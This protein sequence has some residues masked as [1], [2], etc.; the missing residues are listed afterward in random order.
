MRAFV[1]VVDGAAEL[2][3]Q[4]DEHQ[5]RRNDLRQRARRGDDARRELPV[6]AV[7]QHD[8]QRDEPH[9]NDARRHDARG[10]RQQRADENHG[11]G[12][13]AAQRAEQLPHGLEQVL[14]HARAFEDQPHEGEERDRQQRVV[15]HHVVDAARHGLQQCPGQRDHA[16]RMRR[17]LDADD[18]EDEPHCAERERD[19]IAEQQRHDERRE[20][21]RRQILGH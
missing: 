16:A 19:G 8:R 7:A 17:K 14:G 9:G 1:H 2:V 18:E 5:R 13:A 6:I 15:A 4:H 11:I 12:E 20:H 21:D 3:R 10:R